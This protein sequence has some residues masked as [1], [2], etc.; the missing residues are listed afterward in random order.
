VNS[1]HDDLHGLVDRLSS[2][3]VAAVRAIV[4]QLVVE[5][6]DAPDRSNNVKDGVEKNAAGRRRL[7]FAGRLRSGKGDL[8]ARS[9]EILSGELRRRPG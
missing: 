2:D 4:A 3:Q 6:G 8:A 7:S 1:A 9:E 5:A